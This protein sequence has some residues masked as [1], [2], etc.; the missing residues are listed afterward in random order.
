MRAIHYYGGVTPSAQPFGT[1]A[2]ELARHLPAAP[3]E[4][5]WRDSADTSAR[6]G[7]G[8]RS[9]MSAV[10]WDETDNTCLLGYELR[11]M[12]NTAGMR[13]KRPLLGR[14]LLVPQERTGSRI[15]KQS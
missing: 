5:F 13:A 12:A 14:P 2:G 3:E 1:A 10:E 11:R 15:R 4:A 6:P 7:A 9:V 8:A